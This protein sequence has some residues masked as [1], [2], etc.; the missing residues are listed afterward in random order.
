M[1]TKILVIEDDRN[2]CELIGLYLK[3]EGCRV[4]YAHDGS[5]GLNLVRQE[6]PDLIILDIMLP[7]I[8]GLDVCRLIRQHHTIPV[9]ML[10]AKDTS[11]DKIAGLDTGA[12]DYVVKPFDPNE[13]CARVRALLR[14]AVPTKDVHQGKILVLGNLLI[15][16]SQYKVQLNRQ[17]VDLKPKEIALLHFLAS[18]QN[19]V[20]TRDQLLEKVWG[21]DY[22]G[23]TR[24][25]DVHIKRL[26]EK[27]ETRESTWQIKTIWGVGYCFEVEHV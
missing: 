22:T 18:N 3:K 16:M 26:R 10:T 6:S 8:N 5:S 11:E 21:Y 27:L 9:I 2:I 1:S 4:F 15:D 24:T 12:D 7:V 17:S 14:R 23:E 25:V 19:I 13:L 20:F